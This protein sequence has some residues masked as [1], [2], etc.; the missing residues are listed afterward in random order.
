LLLI[1]SLATQHE[2]D[3]HKEQYTWSRFKHQRHSGQD[4]TRPWWQRDKLWASALVA[5][6]LAMCWF[7]A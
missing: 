2:R 6:T 5:C 1:V 3:R 7:F 4:A